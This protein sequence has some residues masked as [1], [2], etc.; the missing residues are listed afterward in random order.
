MSSK[1][2]VQN[3]AH[4]NGT[5]AMTVSSGGVVTFNNVPVNVGGLSFFE[6]TPT[7]ISA[8]TKTTYAHGFGALPKMMEFWLQCI[9]AEEGYV[10]GE[11]AK[12]TQGFHSTAGTSN[13]GAVI[14]ADTTNIYITTGGNAAGGMFKLFN[15]DTGGG[16]TINN[17][18]WK[19]IPRAIG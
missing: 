9:S 2:G 18:K 1:I 15:G 17:T 11:Y 5:N 13:I 12:P 3:I 6:G 16:I 14:Y 10:V 8:S 4:T 19:M 7:A